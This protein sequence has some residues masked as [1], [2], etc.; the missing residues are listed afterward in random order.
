M[1]KHY[2]LISGIVC[3]VLCISILCFGV[4]AASTSLVKLSSTVSFTPSTAKLTIFGGMS[5]SKEAKADTASSYYATNYGSTPVNVSEA[6]VNDQ[7]VAT[8]SEWAYGTATFDD[9]YVET[10]SKT[11]PDSI[12]FFLQI[13][14]HVERDVAITIDITSDYTAQTANI[15]VSCY[16]ALALNTAVA[17]SDKFY[18]INQAT[19]KAPEQS[20]TNAL[21]G[22]DYNEQSIE[23]TGD[24]D[25]DFSSLDTTL[26]TLMVV[27]K[28]DVDDHEESIATDTA[29]NFKVSIV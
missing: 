1:R 29:F 13:T 8:F 15:V 4:Y 22:K 9:N 20:T 17:S 28:L 16:Y 19:P 6:T 26:S 21:V 18:S 10:S 27:I 12:Y 3:I 7:V 23:S 14:N 25:I 2:K 5:G 24:A 11:H